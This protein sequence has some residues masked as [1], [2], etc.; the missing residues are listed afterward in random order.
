MAWL[1]K[2]P[3]PGAPAPADVTDLAASYAA[4]GI[5]QVSRMY[6]QAAGAIGELA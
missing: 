6:E 4:S 2:A 5:R 3:G 1:S